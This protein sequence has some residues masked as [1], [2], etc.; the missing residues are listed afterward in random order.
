MILMFLGGGYPETA[1]QCF[2]MLRNNRFI[3]LLRFDCLVSNYY[4]I[5]LRS[6]LQLISVTQIG[7]RALSKH[8]SILVL[9]RSYIFPQWNKSGY[10]G[11]VI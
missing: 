10:N 6:F 4:A 11:E 5:L 2:D 3:T 8:F 9:G 7:L 1:V